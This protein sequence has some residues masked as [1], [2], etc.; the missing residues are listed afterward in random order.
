M[1]VDGKVQVKAP[2]RTVYDQWTQF[3]EFPKFMEGV[4]EIQQLGE[5]DLHWVMDV[6]GE[7]KGWYAKITRQVPDEVI[8]WESEGGEQ[9]AG[10]VVFRPIDA[11]HTEVE[12][13]LEFGEE[14]DKAPATQKSVEADLKR[15]K[16]F[17]EKRHEETGAYR[18]EIIHG[19]PTGDKG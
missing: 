17:I 5:T 16:D 10:T 3:E 15:F 7:T 13:Y 14:A 1:R 8:A 18:G 6:G 4:K 19:K 9:A 12:F 2:L 11:E